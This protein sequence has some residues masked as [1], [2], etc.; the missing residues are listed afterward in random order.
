[1]KRFWIARHYWDYYSITIVT[2]PPKTC[3]MSSSV[4]FH[5]EIGRSTSIAS[6][7]DLHELRIHDIFSK[8]FKIAVR[9]YA[10]LIVEIPSATSPCAAVILMFELKS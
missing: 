5:K 8:S 1:M 2:C 10:I 9:F 6:A 4:T 3:T 7:L